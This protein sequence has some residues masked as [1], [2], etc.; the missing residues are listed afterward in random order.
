LSQKLVIF[1]GPPG[2][3]KGTQAERYASSKSFAHVS[4]GV[5]LRDHVE[6]KTELGLIA[7]EV[8]DSGKLVSDELVIAMLKERLDYEDAS[9]GAVL[10]GFPRTI[11]QAK[12]L[13]SLVDNNE[14]VAIVL[15][16]VNKK[17]LIDRVLLRG[18][19]DDNETVIEERIKI[20][21]EEIGPL[22][23]HYKEKNIIHINGVGDVGSIYKELS[24]S[25]S[26]FL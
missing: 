7:K 8:L 19:A 2:A 13:D 24:N 14:I 18:R 26:K 22:L 3:G 20:Y 21:E 25:L 5:M 11:P 12:S 6:N 15:F 9:E 1:F 17:E 4:T 10:D 16:E 23:D